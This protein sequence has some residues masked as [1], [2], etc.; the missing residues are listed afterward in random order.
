MIENA[1]L[2][3]ITLR[4]KPMQVI[5]V[6]DLRGG[7]VVAAFRGDRASYR[8]IETPLCEGANPVSVALG[9]RSL[10][11]FATLYVA[12]LDG[13]ERATPDRAAQTRL[14][15]AWHGSEL[16]ID[17]GVSCA[18][19]A[20]EGARAISIVGSESVASLTDYHAARDRAGPDAP[21]S[22]DF[23]GD[24]FTGP[25]DLL[26]DTSLW[27]ERVIVMTLARVGSGEGPD[28]HSLR[29]LIAR[30]GHRQVYAAGGVR[31]GDD[32]R[33]LRDLGASGALVAT[34]LHQGRITR[35]DLEAISAL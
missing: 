3:Y 24:A 18:R 1:P 4:K 16:W 15:H 32:L 29:D 30:A 12:D 31:S 20:G 7:E 35:R 17:D 10:F 2:C 26:A 33:A 28:L 19:A 11:P 5:P 23:R 13:I 6:I 22:L 9:L 27:P 21:L 14:L 34:A 25:P 8:A